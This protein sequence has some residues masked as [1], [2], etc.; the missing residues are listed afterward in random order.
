[1][2][3]DPIRLL[4]AS[5]LFG[6][7]LDEDYELLRAGTRLRRYGTGEAL[8]YENDPGGSAYLIVEG[9]VSIERT[10]PSSRGESETVALAVRG[11]ED[12]IGELSLFDAAPRN[13][14]ARALTPVTA[15]QIRGKHVLFC[16][17]QSPE[18][19]LAL[20]RGLAAKLREATDRR[21]HARV[22]NVRGRLLRELQEEARR[23]GVEE[24]DGLRIP[25]TSPGRRLTQTELSV[26]VGCDRAVINR[27]LA[28]L[29]QE[30][31]IDK[32][33]DSILL[34]MT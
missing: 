22:E 31:R 13:A 4:R 10:A 3:E 19:A 33:R 27:T 17:E 20:I 18:L 25:L 6:G 7:L 2:T 12:L 30:G 15:L 16:A 28:E 24:A 23:Y 8:F 1:L 26:R 11:K 29:A 14:D 9:N 34:R 5:A 21:T 32:T